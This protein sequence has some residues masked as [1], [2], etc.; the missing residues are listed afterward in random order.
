MKT[1][2]I[3]LRATRNEDDSVDLKVSPEF[4]GGFSPE[5]FTHRIAMLLL[6]QLGLHMH[7]QGVVGELA[8]DEGSSLVS[9][10]DDGHDGSTPD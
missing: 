7:A 8:V 10:V 5:E 6:Q 2:T 3:T 4:E 9:L 1:A